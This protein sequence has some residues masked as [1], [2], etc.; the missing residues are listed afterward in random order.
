MIASV[1]NLQMSLE[2]WI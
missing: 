2:K 1:G